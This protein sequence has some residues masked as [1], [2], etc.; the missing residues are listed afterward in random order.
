MN[1]LEAPSVSPSGMLDPTADHPVLSEPD[2]LS[3]SDWLDISGTDRESDDND[4]VFS[5]NRDTDHEH[6]SPL[7]SRRSSVSYGSSRE[8]DID[9]WEGMIEDSADE[10]LPDL[11]P[12]PPP[13][14]LS[15]EE[16]HPAIHAQDET[17][18]E[19]QRINDGLDQSMV[20]TLSS[21]RSSS[22]P[23][24]TLHNSARDLRL[25]FPDPITSSREELRESSYEDIGS[26]PEATQPSDVISVPQQAEEEETQATPEV[27]PVQDSVSSTDTLPASDFNISLYG[28][29]TPSRWSIVTSLLEKVAEGADVTITT[30]RDD[31]SVR[32]F[33]ASSH[34]H[35]LFPHIIT[36]TDKIDHNYPAEGP[37]SKPLPSL[38][39]VYMPSCPPR[40]PEPTFYLPVVAAPHY[41]D[42]LIIPYSFSRELWNAS[43]IPERRA[44]R[45]TPGASA[46]IDER[47]IDSLDP[48]AVYRAFHHVWS[49]N[50]KAV[51]RV[52]IN[53]LRC[54]AIMSIFSAI[55]S[56]VFGIMAPSAVSR[57]TSIIPTSGATPGSCTSASILQLLLPAAE[58]PREIVPPAIESS[59][60]ASIHDFA[61]SVFRAE[62][63]SASIPSTHTPGIRRIHDRLTKDLVLR[64][65]V[66]V[67]VPETQQKPASA[68][69]SATTGQHGGPASTTAS[70]SSLTLSSAPDI[71]NE[72]VPIITAAITNDIQIILDAL[73]GLVQAISKQVHSLVSETALLVQRS[74]SSVEK[75]VQRLE[76]VRDAL[77]ASNARARKRAK[78]LKDRGTKWLFEATEA[79]A[80][81]VQ[82]S[83]GKDKVLDEVKGFMEEMTGR[84]ERA[85]S[86][87]KKVA[88]NLQQAMLE[89]EKMASRAWDIGEEHW[90]QWRIRPH[91]TCRKDRSRKAGV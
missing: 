57:M 19:E 75:N 78:Q 58:R 48:T 66:S 21:S 54:L 82:S 30:S 41:D 14:S 65:T 6:L 64:P 89:N 40:L 37:S 55:I 71:I 31:G 53:D 12:V 3:D 34:S 15:G 52:S 63:T 74:A 4:S 87:A 68:V 8:G 33:A 45:L 16:L 2:T 69:P 22:L 80:S 85:R 91:K 35:K 83:K 43:D 20:S 11:V 81:R 76:N 25:S 32:Q 67:L 39:I 24:S 36:V 61:L 47:D 9:V 18:L 42:E 1:P 49:G 77:Y 56:L 50:K 73:D 60:T 79:V 59:T 86:N 23:A 84:V 72:Y 88:E 51:G 29:P 62:L 26:C 7:R 17:L 46:V 27:A 5:S 28:F 70:L 10:G 44:L 90:K 38:A 13:A